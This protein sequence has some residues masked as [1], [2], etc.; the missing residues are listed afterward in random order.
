MDLG[1]QRPLEWQ[2]G[3]G[4]ACN[5]SLRQF[6]SEKQAIRKRKSYE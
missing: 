5:S 2:Y 3:F 4:E 6:E 1:L